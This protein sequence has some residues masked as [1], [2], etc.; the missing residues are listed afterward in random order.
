[1]AILKDFAQVLHLYEQ[2]NTSLVAVML[3]RR[4]GQFRVHIKGGR[5]WPKKGFEGG[6][7][8]LARG[9]ILVYPRLGETLWVFK[10]WDERARPALGGSL[11]MLHAASYLCEFTEALTRPKSGTRDDSPAEI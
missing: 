6:F 8:L 1:M 4:L 11:S 10:E 7:D 2:G 9:E 3:G 5:R